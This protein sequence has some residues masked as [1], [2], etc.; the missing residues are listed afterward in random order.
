MTSHKSLFGGLTQIH[1]N[2]WP[3]NHL[4]LQLQFLHWWWHSSRT[5]LL[6]RETLWRPTSFS[7]D[8]SSLWSA[9]SRE[10]P[11]ELRKTVS[12]E[13][14]VK[15]LGGYFNVHTLKPLKGMWQY[16]IRSFESTF[17]NC[18]WKRKCNCILALY[19]LSFMRRKDYQ[20]MLL[21]SVHN[22]DLCT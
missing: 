8:L 22:Q 12:T 10:D 13:I 14:S 17:W 7:H 4:L 20:G 5:L 6:S 11:S 19:R 15:F 21:D 3:E 16:I 2:S 1:N 18:Y 9:D